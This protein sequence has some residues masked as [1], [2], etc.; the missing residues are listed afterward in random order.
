M[1]EQEEKS[2]NSGDR[3]T[4]MAVLPESSYIH[5]VHSS[6]RNQDEANFFITQIKANSDGKAPF[7][8][9]DV[10]PPMRVVL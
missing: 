9:S 4:F 5:T 2:E 8:E 6:Q 3:W 10:G 7:F 1:K